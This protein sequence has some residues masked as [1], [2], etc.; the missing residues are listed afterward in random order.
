MKNRIWL[1]LLLLFLGCSNLSQSIIHSISS[2]QDVELSSNP[3]VVNLEPLS[4]H[5]PFSDSD[6]T[7][8]V[9]AYVNGKGPYKFLVL[10]ENGVL[11]PEF[12]TGIL[13]KDTLDEIGERQ[14]PGKIHHAIR[15]F[16][17]SGVTLNN[18]AMEIYAPEAGG[19]D[20]PLNHLDG[21]LT[22]GMMKNLNVSFNENFTK[23]KVSN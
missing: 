17:M 9:E 12:V 6:S 20:S 18:L 22:A 7:K 4:K 14:R 8:V 5:T 10:L 11:D 3:A 16:S 13:M 15:S 23:M 19:E 21:A 1:F 2:P